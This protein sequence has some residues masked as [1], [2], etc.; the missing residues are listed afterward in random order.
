MTPP[1]PIAKVGIGAAAAGASAVAGVLASRLN[2]RAGLAVGGSDVGYEHTPTR[3]EVVVTDDGVGLHVEVDEPA[4]PPSPSRPVVV[5][6]HGYCLS[7]RTWVLQRR[8]LVADGFRVVAYDQ[9]S[10]GRSERAPAASC[11]IDR[12]GHDLHAVISAVAPEGPLVLIGHSMGGMTLMAF[13]EE[14]PEELHERVVAVAF[15]ATSGGGAPLV[16]LGLGPV[17]GS[18][19]GRLAPGV[20]A[21]LGR[22]QDTLLS[23]RRFGRGLEDD[24]VAMWSF[25]SPMSKGAVRFVGDTIF[26][27]PFSV[28]ADFLPTLETYDKRSALSAFSGIECLVLN[29]VGDRLTPPEHSAAIVQRIPGAEHVL[30]ADAGHLVMIEHPRLVN[31]Q[32]LALIDRGSRAVRDHVELTRK[33]RVRRVVTDVARRRRARVSRKAS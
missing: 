7:Q 33:P 10:H 9:R 30:V 20:L 18:A 6:V 4:T 17:V 11:T 22:A 3:E 29:G 23:L 16:S 31:D 19:V 28:M 8:A 24:V 1:S 32:I 15:L 14:Y 12:L 5:L 26:A 27:T 21:R 13:G 25:D 2:R